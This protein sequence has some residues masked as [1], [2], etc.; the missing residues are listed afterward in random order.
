MSLA[1]QVFVH[2]LINVGQINYVG[3]IVVRLIEI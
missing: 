3:S 2:K 1:L